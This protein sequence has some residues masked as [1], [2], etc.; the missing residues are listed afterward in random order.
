MH[1]SF[2]F[3]LNLMF[4]DSVV[5][6]YLQR[7]V[8]YSAMQRLNLELCRNSPTEFDSGFLYLVILIFKILSLSLYTL[9][10]I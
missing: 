4:T 8:G 9:V 7:L 3:L 10:S 5:N 6:G 1:T 2:K